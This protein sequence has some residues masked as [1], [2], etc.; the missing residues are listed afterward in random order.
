MV[1]QEIALKYFKAGLTVFPTNE[2]KEPLCKW[3]DY[4]TAQSEQDVLALFRSNPYGMGL[5]CGVDGLEVIDIDTKNDPHRFADDKSLRFENRFFSE[6]ALLCPTVKDKVVIQRTQ[7]GGWHLIY[8]C[9]NPQGNRKLAR[10]LG[11]KEAILETRGTGGYIV[12][13]PTPHYSIQ[14]GDILNI[15]ILTNE[16]RD[17]LMAVCQSFDQQVK[18]KFD[19][20]IKRNLPN[21]DGKKTCWEDYNSKGEILRLLTDNGWSVCKESASN[22][23]LTRPNKQV[24]ISASVRKS[25]NIFFCFTSSTQFEPN[26]AYSPFAV[27]AFLAHS[28]DFSE[29][30][31]V[32]YQ[33]GYGERLE[34]Q[35]N[36]KKDQQKNI[37]TT[38]NVDALEKVRFD[39][40]QPIQEK[41]TILN[42][43]VGG[44][45]F[46]IAGL[47][48]LVVIAGGQKSR[49]ST[50]GNA[51]IASALSETNQINFALSSLGKNILAFDT[52]QPFERFQKSQHRLFRMAEK[53]GNQKNYS[54]YALRGFSKA[55]RLSLIERK[56]YESENLGIVLLDGIVDLVED[57][58]DLKESSAIVERLMKWTDEKQILLIVVLHLTK[59]TSQLR[60]HLG[61]E[62]QN[63]ADAV[64]E[65]AKSTTEGWTDVCCRESREIPF[66][67]FQFTQNSIGLPVLDFK[68]DVIYE[69][70]YKY[71]K[72]MGSPQSDTDETVCP[73]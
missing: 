24:G 54:A 70:A 60:G 22:Y 50:V 35:L 43:C 72:N 39:Y 67:S 68:E 25:D 58:N 69:N 49:K 37:Q 46:K 29:A 66:P 1:T 23:Y 9:N 20:E 7:S 55:D 19:N 71:S 15:Q 31:R 36:A 10:L 18:P 57:Y 38:L 33:Q 34:P 27:Y 28:G 62:L 11:V 16:E 21:T 5:I 6:L 59:T 2:K 56:I 47:G 30:A 63:K 64:I 8:K 40:H 42:V 73:F 48:N 51:I 32:L 61:T 17:A 12:L 3:K 41:N 13:C 52:E 53:T 14:K 44:D 26:A 65:T 45:W 4:A